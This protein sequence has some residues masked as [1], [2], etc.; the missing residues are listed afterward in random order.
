MALNRKISQQGV[1][2]VLPHDGA[3][4]EARSDYDGYVE[5][6]FT[7][8]DKLVYLDGLK[9]TVFTIDPLSDAQKDALAPLEM[10]ERPWCKLAVRCGLVAVQG[11][12]LYD[13]DGRMTYLDSPER[14]QDPG[15]GLVVTPEWMRR[16]DLPLLDLAS[17]AGAVLR[18]SEM[19]APLSLRSG[20]QS[21]PGSSDGK[22]KASIAAA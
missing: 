3:I 11:Y 18:I 1:R 5:S 12:E 17:I 9:P 14:R 20:Q 19:R 22:A 7:A 16:A 10:G 21:P 15:L 2:L 4:D 6:G 13:G 8:H